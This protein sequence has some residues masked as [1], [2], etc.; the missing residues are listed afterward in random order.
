MLGWI[1]R[2]AKFL[3]SG[4][5]ITTSSE[6]N[7]QSRLLSILNRSHRCTWQPITFV[8]TLAEDCVTA[9]H[10]SPATRENRT[11]P[12][13][14]IPA[15]HS[16]PFVM[17]LRRA[18]LECTGS[19]L[20]ISKVAV[21][22]INGLAR[23]PQMG[24]NTWNGFGCDIDEELIVESAKVVADGLKVYGYECTRPRV[25]VWTFTDLSVRRYCDGRL[26]GS[27]LAV[28]AYQYLRLFCR[29]A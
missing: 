13:T 3:R 20:L 28:S 15:E 14:R 19:L 16:T 1:F 7:I 12:T 11:I 10:H 26:F 6:C 18:I 5:V 9:F 23:T 2:F 25:W 24:W 29:L 27:L 22:Y 4:L 21:G 17:K 8:I